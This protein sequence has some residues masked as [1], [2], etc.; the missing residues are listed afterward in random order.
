MPVRTVESVCLSLNPECSRSIILQVPALSF[1][2]LSRRG[3][4]E[5]SAD[6]R[7][8]VNAARKLQNVRFA[9]TDTDCNARLG[10][11]GLAEHCALDD[12]GRDLMKMAFQ[13]MNLTARSY[14]RILRVARTIAD[15]AG[16]ADIKS[17]HIAE[18]IRYR[19]YDFEN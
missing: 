11:K 17:E 14:D 13:R 7:A 12:A 2:E 3:G 5:S 4:G 8:R 15:L 10:P 1:E 16:S 6:I 19:T 9:G 18:A